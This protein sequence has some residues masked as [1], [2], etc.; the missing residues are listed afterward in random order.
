MDF[1]VSDRLNKLPPYL[2]VEIDKAKR[3]ACAQGKDIIDLGIGDPDEPTP[4]EAIEDLYKAAQDAKNHHY[5]LDQG[6]SVFR[7]RIAT[8]YR[9]RFGV[10][11]DPEK[12]V[13]PL[14]GSK[15]GIS[16]LPLAFIN[17]GDVSL[18]PDPCYPPYKGGTILAGGL[19]YLMPLKEENNFLP[20]LNK[21]KKT[22]LG[23]SKIIY[24]NYPNN[25]TSAVCEK[26]FFEDIAIFARKYNLIAVSDAAYSEIT[27]DNYKAE[28][29]LKVEG[30][31][32]TGVE[33]HSLS[34]TCNM[35]GWR[36]GF[37]CGNEKIIAGI[38]KVKSNIDSGVFNAIQMAGI[39]ALDIADK[40][41]EKMNKI[42]QDRRDA[43]ICSLNKIGWITKKPKATFYVWTKLPRQYKSSIEF[44]ELVLDKADIVITPGIGF[45][46]NGEGYVR[47]AL[48]V[49][50][51]RI[52]EAMDRIEKII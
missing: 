44:A 18:I 30:G 35:T 8:W 25:P 41:S 52:Q 1:K 38:A 20:D 2:F 3:R 5:P 10:T 9:K 31:M 51:E 16:Q 27:F 13:L 36:V 45:G 46:E 6:S 50:K 33:F 26:G 28:S 24:I 48:T 39:T 12:E 14:I 22:A 47:F 29:F 23:K 49:S 4:K 37:V 34:K 42:Y 11:L 21:I 32:E 43:L 40:H 15:E 7:E 17:P 19:P